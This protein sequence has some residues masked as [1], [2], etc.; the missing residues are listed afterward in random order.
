MLDADA[1]SL[2]TASVWP[3][4]AETLAGRRSGSGGRVALGQYVA[5]PLSAFQVWYR[6]FGA[7]ARDERRALDEL[8]AV[9]VA[10]AVGG[11]PAWCACHDE[12]G[13]GVLGDQR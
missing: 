5:G 3:T 1:C 7:G 9:D 12:L 10:W 6:R 4:P 2:C 13:A 11:G 8:Q